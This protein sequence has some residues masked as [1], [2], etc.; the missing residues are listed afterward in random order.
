MLR[1]AKATQDHAAH[2]DHERPLT[3]R[4]RKAARLIGELLRTQDLLPDLV[5]SS[6]AERTQSTARS[7]LEAA[8]SSVEIMGLDQLYLAEPP[9]Y[10]EALRRLGGGAQRVLVVGH[11]PGLE[12]LV[13]RLTGQT[14]HLPTAALVHCRLPIEAWS[15]LGPETQG[16]IQ[17]IFRPKELD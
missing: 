3:K 4:G 11:N 13:F 17:K 14:E 7:A 5:L 2:A 15:E 10:L 16:Q 12:A 1:H 6:T 9:A 8:N